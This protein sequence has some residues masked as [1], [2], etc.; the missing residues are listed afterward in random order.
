MLNRIITSYHSGVFLWRESSQFFLPCDTFILLSIFFTRAY[1]FFSTGKSLQPTGPV[2]INCPI[3]DSIVE[4]PCSI[5]KFTTNTF[6][7]SS[8][9]V[10]H[11]RF[12]KFFRLESKITQLVTFFSDIN[13]TQYLLVECQRYQKEYFKCILRIESEH[14]VFWES[15]RTNFHNYWCTFTLTSL[16]MFS[17]LFSKYFLRCWQG[18]FA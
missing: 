14:K 11:W 9:L 5:G 3:N 2:I 10:H 6:R 17:K 15:T 12:F 4:K 8:F 13:D 16:Y 18:E 7:F 1:K